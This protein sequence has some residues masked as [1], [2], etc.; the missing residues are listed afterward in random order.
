M[1][2]SNCVIFIAPQ[3][4]VAWRSCGSASK[5]PR[6][7]P[8]IAG[9]TEGGCQLPHETARLLPLPGA[10][11]AELTPRLAQA[12]HE[13]DDDQD[14]RTLTPSKPCRV[15]GLFVEIQAWI[16]IGSTGIIEPS[17]LRRRQASSSRQFPR[18]VSE[19]VSASVIVTVP[20]PFSVAVCRQESRDQKERAFKRNYRALLPGNCPNL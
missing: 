19:R 15:R 5:I 3:R 14:P 12:P 17:D 7:T 1:R 20:L 11:S 10:L 18:F 13:I 16:E 8:G 6:S 9:R 4:S 2:V